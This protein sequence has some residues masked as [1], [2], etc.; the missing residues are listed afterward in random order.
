MAIGFKEFFSFLGLY[1]FEISERQKLVGFLE[2]SWFQKSQFLG[3]SDK[4]TVTKRRPLL[5][6]MTYFT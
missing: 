2:E 4:K 3:E 5:S 6:N 1:F